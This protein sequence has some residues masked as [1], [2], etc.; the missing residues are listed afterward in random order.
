MLRHSGHSTTVDAFA[1]F[2]ARPPRPVS[3]GGSAQSSVLSDVQSFPVLFD[4]LEDAL[5]AIK[6]SGLEIV[7]RETSEDKTECFH[8]D[9][10]LSDGRIAVMLDIGSVGNLAGSAWVVELARRSLNN[11]RKPES[12]K[13]DRP[14]TVSGVGTGSQLCNFNTHL[15]I[16]IPLTSG[17]FIKGRYRTPCVPDSKLPA[18]LGLQSLRNSKAIID[19][20]SNRVYFLGPGNYDLLASL[21][22]GTQS[23]QCETAKSGHLMMPVDDFEGLDKAEKEGGLEL[24]E[25]VLPVASATLE[26][27]S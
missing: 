9:V 23:I 15:P 11:G 6:D 22:P 7:G 14:L 27:S 10:C 13:R 24:N 16:S 12:V 3:Q 18:L 4:N 21:P 26:S 1:A 20:N 25:L 17:G 8:T 19:T 2:G 5:D